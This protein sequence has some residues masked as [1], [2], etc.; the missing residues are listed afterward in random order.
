M[1][2][3]LHFWIECPAYLEIMIRKLYSL[4]FTI[5]ATPISILNDPDQV[6]LGKA[7]SQM[8]ETRGKFAD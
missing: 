5:D 8:L 6:L 4:F 7:L 3:D 2:G 1:E